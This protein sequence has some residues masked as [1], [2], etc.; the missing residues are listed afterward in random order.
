MAGRAVNLDEHLLALLAAKGDVVSGR[1]AASWAQG[2]L[3]HSPPPSYPL[4]NNPVRALFAYEKSNVLKLLDSG[5]GGPD[6]L[7]KR[8]QSGSVMYGLCRL[9]DAATGQAHVVLISW[10]G[11]MPFFGACV[12]LGGEAGVLSGPS[13]CPQ[14]GEGVPEQQRKECA[15]HLPAIRAFFKEAALVVAASQAGEVAQEGLMRTVALRALPGGNGGGKQ[16]QPSD[17][18]ERVGTS[19]RKTN[20]ALELLRSKR[21][22]FWAQAERE[23]EERREAERRE[24]QDEQR[25]WERQRMEAERREA[26]ERERRVQAREQQIEAWR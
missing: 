11:W 23:E 5:A 2:S 14:V 3:H 26:A 12:G 10:A 6:E 13:V 8:L 25:R 4:N 7:A 1:A 9:P 24:A 16:V 15:G 17:P 18:Q 19:Y 21:G 22:S 20:P